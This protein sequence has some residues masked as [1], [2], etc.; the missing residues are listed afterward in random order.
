MLEWPGIISFSSR[1]FNFTQYIY[2][3]ERNEQIIAPFSYNHFALIIPDVVAPKLFHHFFGNRCHGFWC[4]ATIWLSWWLPDGRKEKLIFKQRSRLCLR[5]FINISFILHSQNV[6]CILFQIYSESHKRKF[7]ICDC[8]LLAY[9]FFSFYFASCDGRLI[10]WQIC[11]CL[12]FFS[13][14]NEWSLEY[15]SG[16]F[17]WLKVQWIEKKWQCQ[18]EE[19]QVGGLEVYSFFLNIIY[20]L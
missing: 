19:F 6:D 9:F 12:N 20:L 2:I 8:I 18:T 5:L 1:L 14:L 10:T 13:A 11:L 15:L 17:K 3:Y 4:I 16:W 7:S